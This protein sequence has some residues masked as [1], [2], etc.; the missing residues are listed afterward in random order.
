M[1]IQ[2]T[3]E[4]YVI[5]QTAG[6]TYIGDASSQIYS[7]N[8]HLIGSS[9]TITLVDQG[10][11]NIIELVA[12]LE[13][14]SSMITSKKLQLIVN[15][16]ATINIR[17]ADTFSFNVGMNKSAGD[18]TG[19]AKTFAEFT[20]DILGINVPQQ[21]ANPVQGAATKIND[22]GTATR[23]GSTND[24]EA[25]SILLSQATALSV[26][27]TSITSLLSLSSQEVIG[28]QNQWGLRWSDNA[29]TYSFPSSQ[30]TDY[31][32]MS[33][34]TANWSALTPAEQTAARS[35]FNELASIIPL[36]FT[37]VSGDSGDIR[38]SVV[39][40]TNDE[41][42]FAY[43]PGMDVRGDVFLAST[44]RELGDYLPKGENYFTILH[45]LGHAMGLDHPFDGDLVPSGTDN[46][47]YT[48]MSYT[49][50]RNLVVNIS[51][52]GNQSTAELA[53]LA[54]PINYSLF[55]IAALQVEYGANLETHVG[56]DT[57]SLSSRNYDYLTIWD[58]GGND[59]IDVSNA[60]GASIINLNPGTHS[61]IDIW[62]LEQQKVADLAQHPGISQR[63]IS[64]FYDTLADGLY[65]GEN[66]LAIA[67]GVVI[68][69]LNTGAGDDQIT[70]NPYD[71]QISTAAGNDQITLGQG[72]FDSID[73]GAGTDSILLPNHSQAQIQYAQQSDGS[74]I[75][76]GPDFAA[77]LIGIEQLSLQDATLSLIA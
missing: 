32:G 5:I 58:A 55:D 54:M 17:G 47:D 22:D 61:S 13:I 21:G 75:L 16:G 12:G 19:E 76:L 15:N 56:S 50:A 23:G 77:Q 67:Y 3:A 40:M 38:F 11:S 70:D 44:N 63:V 34:L 65:T 43:Y 18:A 59:T 9:D 68:E 74:Y 64:Y 35:V 46:L 28:L 20:N 27:N 31:N 69:N 42:G 52:E 29:L 6:N 2:N 26:T 72:G 36:S 10:G 30:P 4:P 1:A 53:Y 51:E 39:S 25:A 62:P 49:R 45:E 24:D 71:N 60:T 41:L 7:L 66:N 14:S 8:P 33:E 57:Y 48:L 73:G 37:E